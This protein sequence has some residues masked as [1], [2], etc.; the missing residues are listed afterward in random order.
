MGRNIRPNYEYCHD[1][2]KHIQF[3]TDI[4]Q[5]FSMRYETYDG[6]IRNKLVRKGKLF[7]SK[8]MDKSRFSMWT[9]KCAVAFSKKWRNLKAQKLL[10]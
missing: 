10:D 1:M 6:L 2:V 3:V 7:V 9:L 5:Y 4:M 8:N